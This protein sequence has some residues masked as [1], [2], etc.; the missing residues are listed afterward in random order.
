V[1]L[2]KTFRKNAGIVRQTCHHLPHPVSFVIH[3]LRYNWR[4]YGQRYS[5]RRYIKSKYIFDKYL[6]KYRNKEFR[7]GLIKPMAPAFRTTNIALFII[8]DKFKFCIPADMLG[9]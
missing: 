2:P 5:N 6:G 1:H 3:I 7:A 9:L 8:R 4:L